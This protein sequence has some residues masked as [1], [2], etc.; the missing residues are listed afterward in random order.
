[1][2]DNVASLVGEK[3]SSKGLELI[4]DVDPNLPDNLVGDP[5]RIGQILINYANNSVKFTDSGEIVVRASMVTEQEKHV[6]VRFEVEDTGIGMS[7]EQKTRLFESFS[8]ADTS[9]TRKY[10]AD[11]PV[12]DGDAR[13]WPGRGRRADQDGW[14]GPLRTQIHGIHPG[15]GRRDSD[16]CCGPL[17]SW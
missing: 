13:E 14:I 1:M 7:E 2:L 5:L 15:P 12:F 10:G 11:R 9:T 17:A 4:F 3:A 16:R 6:V 8:Q